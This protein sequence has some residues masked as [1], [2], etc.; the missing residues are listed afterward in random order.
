MG[1]APAHSHDATASPAQA[2]NVHLNVARAAAAAGNST[3]AAEEAA[4]AQALAVDAGDMPLR[5]VC[6]R[7]YRSSPAVRR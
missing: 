1:L 3:W 2:A 4:Q 7:G 5:V 6:R